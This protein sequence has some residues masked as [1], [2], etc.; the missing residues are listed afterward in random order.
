MAAILELADTAVLVQEHWRSYAAA[1]L[2][3]KF[4]LQPSNAFEHAGGTRSV[5][6]PESAPAT[7]T[8]EPKATRELC[9]LIWPDAV[10]RA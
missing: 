8:S 2:H 4:A 9:S 7:C 1:K 5:G 3:A 6:Q 10:S